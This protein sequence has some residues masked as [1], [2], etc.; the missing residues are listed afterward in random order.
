MPPVVLK[1]LRIAVLLWL[2]PGLAAAHVTSTGVAVLDVD[3]TRLDY[4]LT[5]NAEEVDPLY[6]PILLAAGKGEPGD[7][8]RVETALGDY[9]RFAIDGET[10]RPQT[11]RVRASNGKLL[12]ELSLSC[13]RSVG[14]LWMRDDWPEVM[15]AH[16]QTVLTVNVAQRVAGQFVFLDARRE[17]TLELQVPIATDWMSFI[18]MGAEHILGGP[19]HLLF[20]I[21]LL[22]LSRSLWSTVKIVTGFTVGHSITLSLATLG[23]IEVPSSIVEPLIAASIIWVALENIISPQSE[24]R[25]WLVATFFGLVHGLGFA[26]GLLE[27]GLP[28]EALIR[29]LIG[30]NIGVE[31]AQI[32]FVALVLPAIAWA[33]Q[34]GRLVRLPQ[35]MSI[36]AAVAGA[37]WLLQR[38]FFSP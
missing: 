11:A 30:F 17:A 31:L 22:A 16:F 15:G 24:G 12:L 19:D 25:R 10:C 8:A 29:A 33:S 6:V 36:C 9:A 4:R 13:A 7:V 18:L 2:L 37:A 21:A 28:H 35:A 32:L 27:L 38:V 3:G 26:G 1:I 14:T 23:W 20:L 5:L 34:P